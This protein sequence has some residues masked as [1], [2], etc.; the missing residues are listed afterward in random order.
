M[1]FKKRSIKILIFLVLA[2]WVSPFSLEAARIKDLA[3]IKGIRSNQLTGYGLVVGL[4]GTG[5]KD[6]VSFTRQSLVNMM[7]KI[8]IHDAGGQL[9]V[10]NVASV[11]VTAEIEPFARIGDRMDVTV[12]SLGD[13]KS[14]KGGTLLM[15]PL[16]GVD[17]QVYGLAQGAVS[18]AIPSGAGDRDSHLLVARVVDGATVEREIPF[19]LDGKHHLILFLF[20]PDFTTARRM[21]DTINITV[22][23]GSAQLIDASALRLKIPEKMRKAWVA[24]F[25]AD[26]ETLSVVPDAPAR[27]V[28]NEKTGTVVIGSDVTISSVA[29]AH[30]D[31]SVTINPQGGA[32][33]EPQ[34]D[35]VMMLEEN[36]TIGELVRGL[37]ALGVKPR[38]LISILEGIKVAGALQAELEIL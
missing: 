27:V 20:R 9:K 22:G 14:L 33:E 28:I 8:N 36:S 21:A 10:K 32:D 2:V 35:R 12:S 5:D 3:A 31:L 13:A 7:K 17:G 23:K 29:V 15:S 1:E 38:D 26:I 25:I 34:E 16:K 18:L 30:G 24:E 6:K 4:N 37:N 19:K 11:M